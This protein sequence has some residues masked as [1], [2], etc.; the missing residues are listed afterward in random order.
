MILFDNKM[1]I[2]CIR[3][4]ESNISV[5]FKK[6]DKKIYLESLTDGDKEIKFTTEIPILKISGDGKYDKGQDFD[7]NMNKILKNDTAITEEEEQENHVIEHENKN[8]GSSQS[9]VKAESRVEGFIPNDEEVEKDIIQKIITFIT[10]KDINKNLIGEKLLS[11]EEPI[12]ISTENVLYNIKNLSTNGNSIGTNENALIV[13][14]PNTLIENKG[15]IVNT[16]KNEFENHVFTVNN[17]LQ[18]IFNENIRA[19]LYDEIFNIIKTDFE[20]VNSGEN[21]SNENEI[22][23][24]NVCNEKFKEYYNI[25]NNLDCKKDKKELDK[26]IKKI[27][28]KVHP[29]KHTDC[30]NE[31][32]RASQAL[33]EKKLSC[34][35]EQELNNKKGRIV[36]DINKPGE[37]KPGEEIQNLVAQDEE[38]NKNALVVFENKDIASMKGPSSVLKDVESNIQGGKKNRTKKATKAGKKKTKRVRFVITKKGRKNK[39]NRT[40]R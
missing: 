2:I 3:M 26:D 34:I 33:S 15:K 17:D 4:A 9:G 38:H 27:L 16:I 24:N 20:K 40:R 23:Q 6:K 11:I 29:D 7:R 36:L 22:S 10:N 32:T 13:Y 37:N 28:F 25:I 31:A 18:N 35:A 30:N 39:K 8:V 19:E 14:E 5:N 1:W 12:K 21:K